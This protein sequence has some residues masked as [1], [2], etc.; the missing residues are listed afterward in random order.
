MPGGFN[1]VHPARENKTTTPQPTVTLAA[2]SRPHRQV[3]GWKER[4]WYRL[5]ASKLYTLALSR[6]ASGDVPICV[7]DLNKGAAVA[8]RPGT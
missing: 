8:K 4:C 7:F 5:H 2:T 3:F 6:A 1:V